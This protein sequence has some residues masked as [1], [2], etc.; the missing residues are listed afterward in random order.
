MRLILDFSPNNHCGFNVQDLSLYSTN[1][2]I[3]DLGYENT[4]SVNILYYNR[5]NRDSIISEP[6]FYMHNENVSIHNYRSKI[7]EDG[8]ITLIH[9]CLPT[10][11]Y[12]QEHPS[13]K[14]V[15][16]VNDCSFFTYNEGKINPL[17]REEL[18]T[19]IFQCKE[20]YILNYITYDFVSIC[21][22]E[23]CYIN[24]CKQLLDCNKCDQDDQVVYRKDLL[25]ILLD[26]VRY[27]TELNKFKE[28]ELLIEEL[29]SCK[30]LCGI[31]SKPSKCNCCCS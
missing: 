6:T 8:W 5:F 28:A 25:K 17:S 9:M 1:P 7:E 11:E 21:Q 2:S 15:V 18:V 20:D 4:V 10:L 13:N 29:Q 31:L 23:E 22:L 30:G 3:E 16:F 27:L 14:P 12:V 26:T 19:Y 24:Y